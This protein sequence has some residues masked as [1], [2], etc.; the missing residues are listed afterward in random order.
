MKSR[1]LIVEHPEVLS[2]CHIVLCD[3]KAQLVVNHMKLAV[4]VGNRVGF[5]FFPLDLGCP[6]LASGLT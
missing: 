3:Q 2:P 6:G 1:G 5:F 4:H